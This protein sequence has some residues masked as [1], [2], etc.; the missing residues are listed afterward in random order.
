MLQKRLNLQF[1]NFS[2]FNTSSLGL[3]AYH[4]PAFPLHS[5]I[6]A[7]VPSGLTTPSSITRYLGA[8]DW[9][10]IHYFTNCSGFYL[11]SPTNPS[12]L[13]TTKI[14]STCTR[15]VSGYTFK[16]HDAIQSQLL[17]NVNDLAEYVSTAQHMTST[18]S[19]LWYAGIGNGVI[20]GFT[21]PWNFKGKRPGLNWWAFCDA[22]VRDFL[23]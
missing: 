14:N 23:L 22:F 4:D 2:K 16:L 17:P 20:G 10:T 1:T 8:H 11:P 19:S 15:Q 9:Y 12:L 21:L 6:T 5:N 3:D 7:L 18:W 13:T